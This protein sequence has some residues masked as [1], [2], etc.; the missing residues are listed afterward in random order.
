MNTEKQLQA[1]EAFMAEPKTRKLFQA[2]PF[3]DFMNTGNEEGRAEAGLWADESEPRQV[4]ID[5][6]TEIVTHNHF[7]AEHGDQY[8]SIEE[9]WKLP[10]P[11][12]R[13]AFAFDDD[14]GREIWFFSIRNYFRAWAEG[15]KAVF[16]IGPKRFPR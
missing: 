16:K 9:W 13:W 12:D 14:D 15:R 5:F 1:F 8:G 2:Q 11:T 4:L 7:I 3:L 6:F 10:L